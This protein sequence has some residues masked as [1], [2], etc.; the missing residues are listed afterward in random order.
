MV[1]PTPPD[2]VLSPEYISFIQH[3]VML[4]LVSWIEYDS[5]SSLY[6]VSLGCVSDMEG[7]QVER[8]SRTET[9]V[10]TPC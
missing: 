6:R 4:R 1:P 10:I 9:T 2:P 7:S 5:L 3:H 8:V